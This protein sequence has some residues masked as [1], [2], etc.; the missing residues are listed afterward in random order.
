M[1]IQEIEKVNLSIEEKQAIPDGK[2]KPLFYFIVSWE[3]LGRRKEFST[4]GIYNDYCEQRPKVFFSICVEKA[5]LKNLASREF[6]V[7]IDWENNTVKVDGGRFGNGTFDIKVASDYK[8][9]IERM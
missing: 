7:D 4:T 3:R 2:Q 1:N 8:H 9:L 5:C 6:V